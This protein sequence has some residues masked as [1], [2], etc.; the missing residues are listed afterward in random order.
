[1]QRDHRLY[2]PPLAL[3]YKASA[4]NALPPSVFE[5]NVN[6]FAQEEF[7]HDGEPTTAEPKYT[8]PL[9][10]LSTRTFVTC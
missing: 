5:S 10:V 2:A 8:M 3:A 4:S 9:P 1:M 6:A 7:I